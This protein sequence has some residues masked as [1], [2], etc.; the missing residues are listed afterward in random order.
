MIGQ[1]YP[2]FFMFDA[3]DL[4]TIVA[5]GKLFKTNCYSTYFDLIS[6]KGNK[7]IIFKNFV[8]R[9][10]EETVNTKSRSSLYSQLKLIGKDFDSSIFE[11]KQCVNSAQARNGSIRA[12]FRI[13]ISDFTSISTMLNH[14]FSDERIKNWSI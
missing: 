4:H 12:E 10:L 7:P 9:I 1:L 13:H 14:L 6:G 8:K 3:S 2:N 11:L 5:S